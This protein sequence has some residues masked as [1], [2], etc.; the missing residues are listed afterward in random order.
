VVKV[1]K[2]SITEQDEKSFWSPPLPVLAPP[3][4]TITK[5]E[6]S[7]ENEALIDVSI[8][9]TQPATIKKV[10]YYVDSIL[11]GELD[12]PPFEG[13]VW[14][15]STLPEG[16]HVL[17]VE[18]VQVSGQASYGETTVRCG[19]MSTVSNLT[20]NIP[21]NQNYIYII[22]FA[23]LLILILV[24]VLLLKRKGRAQQEVPGTTKVQT[25]I[26][27]SEG[28]TAPAECGDAPSDD[29]DDE[30]TTMDVKPLLEPLAKLTV[31]KSQKLDLGAIFKVTSN[32]TI[33]RG[34]ENDIRI[35]DKPVSRKHS[36]INYAGNRFH[37]RD[38]KSTYGTKVDD[39]KVTGSGTALKDGAIIQFGTGT[40]MEFNVLLSAEE[41]KPKPDEDKD[42]TI[43]YDR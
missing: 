10:R 24:I 16:L 38:L 30:V 19:T 5:T 15:T 11:A 35:P 29:E 31:I 22:L 9:I 23:A 4:V 14:D 28:H 1:T 39:K 21:D 13:F 25:A 32:T 17:R 42:K 8:N 12:G 3:E 18:A 6:K 2:G 33:G 34:S 36:I 26:K 37:I 40:V 20:D 27:H 41:D 7:E 43:L